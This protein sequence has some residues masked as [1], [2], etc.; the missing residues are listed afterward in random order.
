[1]EKLRLKNGVLYDLAV[2]GVVESEEDLTIR[3]M[4]AEDLEGFESAFSDAQNTER[5][6]L[7][8]EGGELLQ[9]FTGYTVFRSIKKEKDVFIAY[10]EGEDEE[11]QEIRSDVIT[12]VLTKTDLR[13]DLAEVRAEMETY[14]G[15]IEEL[16][17]LVAEMTE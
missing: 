12:V 16:G 2:N 3:I 4:S 14:A 17:S 7:V 6:E 9:P 13:A 1:M 15:A 5:L 8:T 10:E 11:L